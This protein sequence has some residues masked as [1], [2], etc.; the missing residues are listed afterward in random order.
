MELVG[1]MRQ[2]YIV[3][4]SATHMYLIDQHAL[5]ERIT[6]ER[7]KKQVAQDGYQPEIL[8]QPGKVDIPPGVEVDDMIP[9]LETFGFDV[10]L[11]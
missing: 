11:L 6:F 8:L 2:M 4:S 7:M 9:Q 10:S 1:Q 5:A 3:L